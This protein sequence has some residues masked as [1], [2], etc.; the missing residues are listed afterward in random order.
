[1]TDFCYSGNFVGN[2]FFVWSSGFLDYL[3]VFL[4]LKQSGNDCLNKLVIVHE[5]V[6]LKR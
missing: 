3:L 5:L 6:I 4:F 1:M 2:Y